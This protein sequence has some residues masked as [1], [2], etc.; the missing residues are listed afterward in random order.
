MSHDLFVDGP[1]QCGHEGSSQHPWSES[2][3]EST[4]SRGP[5]DLL[6]GD[7]DRVEL[8]GIELHLGLDHIRRMGHHRGQEPS[9]NAAR[10]VRHGGFGAINGPVFGSRQSESGNN[11][12]LQLCVEHQ[13]EA[14][15]GRIPHQG[16]NK[17]TA[18]ATDAFASID[19]HESLAHLLVLVGARLEA[20]L[21]DRDRD[22]QGP[23]DTPSRHAQAD[24][25]QRRRFVIPVGHMG[26]EPMQ[27]AEIKTH[28]GY[29]T[30]DRWD[31][32]PPKPGNSLT[33]EHLSD[34][35]EHAHGVNEPSSRSGRGSKGMI[36]GGI[37]VMILNPSLDQIEGLEQDGAE[38]SR[39]GS[40]KEGFHHGV[41]GN[42]H[43]GLERSDDLGEESRV[44]IGLMRSR[45]EHQREGNQPMRHVG[46][47]GS[48]AIFFVVLSS[49]D[50]GTY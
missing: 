48:V 47:P 45:G 36:G 38:G 27:G 30:R 21:D 9:E 43:L 33:F 10:E 29:R 6:H 28:T 12:L 17:A 24:G 44:G 25:L 23:G 40:S 13:I 35:G 32:T 14:G 7:G 41:R 15:K 2:H 5:K 26:L 39:E 11:L 50:G 42:I 34:H 8:L 18:Q 20:G 31:N 1:S 16:G 49:L 22:D 19:L 3:H 37:L 4:G 46:V